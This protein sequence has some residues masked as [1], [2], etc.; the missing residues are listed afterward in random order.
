MMAG[1]R[2]GEVDQNDTKNIGNDVGIRIAAAAGP[3]RGSLQ[4]GRVRRKHWRHDAGHGQPGYLRQATKS[5]TGGDVFQGR[6]LAHQGG[7]LEKFA[8]GETSPPG[9][10]F[11]GLGAVSWLTM[12]AS[13]AAGVVVADP[14]FV[15]ASAHWAPGR[16]ESDPPHHS[17]VFGVVWSTSPLRY[18]PSSSMNH[19]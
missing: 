18:R 11:V 14:S 1:Y 3:V 8:E 13:C 16:C 5:R 10:L 4:N 6:Q 12:A 15:E 17:N 7:L 9:L 19:F 2:K